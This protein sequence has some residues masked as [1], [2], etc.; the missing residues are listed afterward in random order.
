MRI[1]IIMKISKIDFISN[2]WKLRLK[3]EQQILINLINLKT[4]TAGGKFSSQAPIIATTSEKS[5]TV[6]YY[7]PKFV[8]Q[9]H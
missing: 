2:C 5:C 6:N 4:S 1:I 7:L 9:S 8:T 3:F